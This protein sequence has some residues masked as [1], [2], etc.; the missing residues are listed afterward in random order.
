MLI[1]N[2]TITYD[3]YVELCKNT[4]IYTNNTVTY[5]KTRDD[6]DDYM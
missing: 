1:Q 4:P 2:G 3:Q 5:V 6:E